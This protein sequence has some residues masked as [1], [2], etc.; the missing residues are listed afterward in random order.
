MSPLHTTKIAE[1]PDII[2]MLSLLLCEQLSNLC[3]F[4]VSCFLE[5]GLEL[6]REYICISP[7]VQFNVCKKFKGCCLLSLQ[8]QSSGS[9]TLLKI[10]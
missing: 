5:D 6:S 9:N 3:H 4:P 8:T 10:L 7:K 2:M 1:Q